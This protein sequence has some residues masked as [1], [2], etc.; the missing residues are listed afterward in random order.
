MH[1]NRVAMRILEITLVGIAHAPSPAYVARYV[2]KCTR[3]MPMHGSFMA[4]HDE[5]T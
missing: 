3:F 1:I 5:S 2:Y 4:L